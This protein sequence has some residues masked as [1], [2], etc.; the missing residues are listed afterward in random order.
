M[1]SSFVVEGSGEEF[2][3]RLLS[4]I[5]SKSLDLNR[6][7]P[8]A[9]LAA[10]PDDVLDVPCSFLPHEEVDLPLVEV[11]TDMRAQIGDG[12]RSRKQLFRTHA[13]EP[14]IAIC[15][16]FRQPRE[17]RLEAVAIRFNAGSAEISP[18][19]D[20]LAR[21]ALG[22]PGHDGAKLLHCM[23]RKAAMRGELASEHG[24][25]RRLARCMVDLE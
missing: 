25:D 24:Q 18:R 7:E 13:I 5:G 16:H 12:A 2:E 17:A 14:N 19:K 11:S 10:P 3:R 20:V 15:L 9:E 22:L 21:P 23:F 4:H 1:G 8:E 6:R